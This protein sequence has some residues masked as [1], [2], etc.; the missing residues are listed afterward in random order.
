MFLAA[1]VLLAL[2]VAVL[3]AVWW[4]RDRNDGDAAPPP[5]ERKPE[6]SPLDRLRYDN[7]P[8]EERFPTWQPANLVAVIGEHRQRHWGPVNAVAFR[9]DGKVVAS[10]GNETI[11]RLWLVRGT[12]ESGS[13][14]ELIALKGHTSWVA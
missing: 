5:G 13:G 6:V 4:P 10:A 14:E 3:A 7:I 8:T 2:G 11:V 9:P 12:R 1:S